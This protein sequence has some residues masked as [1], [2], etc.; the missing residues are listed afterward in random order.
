MKVVVERL[1]IGAF[2]EAGW[3]SRRSVLDSRSLWWRLCEC[4]IQG[5]KRVGGVYKG[6]GAR[7]RVNARGREN[8]CTTRTQRV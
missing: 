2:L 6:L 4:V 3:T 7:S 8:V 5:K 1:R